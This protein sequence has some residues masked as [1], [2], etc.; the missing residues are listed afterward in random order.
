MQTQLPIANDTSP[1]LNNTCCICNITNH[2][3]FKSCNLCNIKIH[4]SCDVWN[5]SDS[6]LCPRCQYC[7]DTQ[8]SS[9]LPCRICDKAEGMFIKI[10]E[11]WVHYICLL[12]TFKSLNVNNFAYLCNLLYNKSRKKCIY[13]KVEKISVKVYFSTVQS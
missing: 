13:C 9:L 8:A 10:E 3:K 7:I 5:F 6:F 11:H 2:E 1:E 4:S 12:F